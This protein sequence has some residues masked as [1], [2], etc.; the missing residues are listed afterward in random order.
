MRKVVLFATDLAQQICIT[1]T[2][3]TQCI[4]IYCYDNRS[5]AFQTRD[6]TIF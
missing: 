4:I 2:H 5:I 3:T 6:E 1:H